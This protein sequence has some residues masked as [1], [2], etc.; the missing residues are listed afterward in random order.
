[1]ADVTLELALRL[2]E[3][4][5]KLG[6]HPETGKPV[7]AHNGRFGP[8][9]QCDKETRSLPADVSLLDVTLEQALAILA[10]PKVRGRGR[11]APKEPVK[12]LAE[13]PIT[14]KPVQVLDGRYGMYVTDGETNASLPKD[15]T[16]DTLTMELALQL[17]ADRAAM[18]PAKRGKKRVASRKRASSTR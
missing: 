12:T 2:L 18:G 14:R 16:P 8:Y 15:V 17:L 5:R 4:P 3:L 11:A 13:S 7:I 10:Q 6:E 9:L 1:P